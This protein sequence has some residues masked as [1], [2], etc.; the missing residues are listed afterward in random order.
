MPYLQ[1]QPLATLLR[2]LLVFRLCRVPLIVKNARPLLAGL[3][4]LPLLGPPLAHALIRR[5]FFAQF[6]GGESEAELAP[7]VAALAREGVGSILDYAAEADEAAV[8]EPL[9][10]HAAAEAHAHA[11]LRLCQQGVAAAAHTGGFAAVKVTGIADPEVLK[12]VT[13]RMHEHRRAFR[14]LLPGGG[15]GSED[16]PLYLTAQLTREAFLAALAAR[17]PGA[18]PGAAARLWALCDVRGQGRLDYLAFC[19][20]ARLLGFGQA[21][22]AQAAAEACGLATPEEALALLLGTPRPTA[23]A[24]HTPGSLTPAQ[25]S[26]WNSAL[27]RLG[28]LCQTAHALGVSLM[29]DAEQTY[30]QGAIDLAVVTMQRAHNPPCGGAN[31]AAAAPGEGAGEGA[32]LLPEER[33]ALAL[34][35]RV[36]EGGAREPVPAASAPL[37]STPP[38]APPNSPPPII[39][40]FNTCELR[41]PP[42]PLA[43]FFLGAFSHPPHTQPSLYAPLSPCRPVLPARHALPPGPGPAARGAGGLGAGGETCAGGLHEPGAR[44]G[45]GAGVP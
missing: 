22:L 10:Q 1:R 4:R 26:A 43:R 39:P 42:P 33:H 7:L 15:G 9:A 45:A 6:V 5:T 21:H 17:S 44:A 18:P 13:A 3:Q 2:S 36:K 29:V 41:G 27:G 30:L 23:A 14:A 24:S 12:H 28:Q 25:R 11:C 37:E 31:A 34:C 19:D 40:V 16:A 20:A 8:G 32:A 38:L 35:A